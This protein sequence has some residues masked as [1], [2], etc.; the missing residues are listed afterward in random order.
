MD[1]RAPRVREARSDGRPGQSATQ[2]PRAQVPAPARGGLRRVHRRAVR[3]HRLPAVL[4][5]RHRRAPR[6][7]VPG[8]GGRARSC[9]TTT[10]SSRFEDLVSSG[11]GRRFPEPSSAGDDSDLA[12]LYT[13]GTMGKPKGVRLS[14]RAVIETAVLTG[15]A[16]AMSAAD[17]VSGRAA[18]VHDLRLWRRGRRRRGRRDARA[19]GGVRCA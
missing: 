4:R 16:I 7:A 2:L 1:R 13:S 18:A 8:H 17:R 15:D 3:R 14:H 12:L 6:P 5:G 10:G 9:G 19:A 11:E